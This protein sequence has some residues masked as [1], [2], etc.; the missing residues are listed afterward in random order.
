[1]R[2]NI[3]E[4]SRWHGLCEKETLDIVAVILFQKF[5]LHIVFDSLGCDVKPQLLAHTDDL[6][7]QRLTILIADMI[8]QALIQL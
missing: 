8:D 2:Q 7:Q 6:V 4:L 3:F 1:M 5:Q